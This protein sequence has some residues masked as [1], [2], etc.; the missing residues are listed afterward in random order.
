MAGLSEDFQ[1]DFD[2]YKSTGGRWGLSYRG[3]REWASIILINCQ[4]EGLVGA[5]K[6]T[7]TMVRIGMGAIQDPA[8]VSFG[9]R[10]G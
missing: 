7:F 8:S 10:E 4:R 5:C 2:V 9:N 3:E 1:K 6:S